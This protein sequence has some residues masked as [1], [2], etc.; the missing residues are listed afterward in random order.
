MKIKKGERGFTLIELMVVVAVV[1]IL[2]SVS[3]PLFKQYQAKARSAEGKLILSMIF[4]TQQSW[5]AQYDIYTDCLSE[6][7]ITKPNS[8]F[9]SYG[10]AAAS[11]IT[12]NASVS[13]GAPTSCIGADVFFEGTKAIGQSTAPAQG[14]VLTNDPALIVSDDGQS[15]QATAVAFIGNTTMSWHLTNP[16]FSQVHASTPGA[17]SSTGVPY[18]TEAPPVA[19]YDQD[20]SV[21]TVSQNG[22]ETFNNKQ[23]TPALSSDEWT[24]I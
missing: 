9:Y 23:W 6:M 8:H 12:E 22:I 4:K 3:L 17:S 15:Y 5:Y 18:G 1:G 16:L 14:M 11:A 2:S 10:F 7:G 20:V 24:Q 13:M 19:I 21:G